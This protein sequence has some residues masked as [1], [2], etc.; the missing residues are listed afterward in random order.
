MKYKFFLIILFCSFAS[1]SHAQHLTYDDIV[2]ISKFSRISAISD[3]V[4]QRGYVY[5]GTNEEDSISTVYWTRNCSVNIKDGRFKW[6]TGQPRSLFSLVI[7]TNQF[8][9]YD[10]ELPSRNAY[11]ALTAS[12]KANGFKFQEEEISSDR[13]SSTYKRNR[14]GKIDYAETNEKSGGYFSSSFW[15]NCR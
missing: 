9:R 8:I 5:A 14:G 7:I 1:I 3:F 2:R 12:L 6:T 15:F 10:Y 11:K 4:A 13:I